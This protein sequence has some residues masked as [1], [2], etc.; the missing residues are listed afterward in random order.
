MP[1][2][3]KDPEERREEILQAARELFDANGYEK[4]TMRDVM[5]K[6]N[7]AKG[8]IYHY[9]RSKNDLLEAVIEKMVEDDIA[10]KKALLE[11]M[12]GSALDKIRTLV[13]AG[14]RMEDHNSLLEH[15]HLPGNTGM[16]TQQLAV[17]ISRQA[18]IYGELVQQ[19]CDEGIFE[20]DHPL[21]CAEFILGGLQFL[22]DIG[23]YPWAQEDLVRRAVAFPAMIEA[24][25]K[26]PKGSFDFLVG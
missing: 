18:V 7:I 25:L 17:L 8:T 4:T 2:I 10:E 5:D 9:F 26:A 19:G 20:T 1:R 14:N 3:V 24:L 16:H 23:I 6:L 13:E 15:L 11:D 21:E 12:S 22:T